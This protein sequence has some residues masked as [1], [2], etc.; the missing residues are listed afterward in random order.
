MTFIKP[1]KL[2][3]LKQSKPIQLSSLMRP[4]KAKQNNFIGRYK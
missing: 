2:P 4:K 3:K 1:Q